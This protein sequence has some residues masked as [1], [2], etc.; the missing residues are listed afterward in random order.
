MGV[1]AAQTAPRGWNDLVGSD[2]ETTFFHRT[3]WAELLIEAGLGAAGLYLYVVEGGELSVGIPS[4]VVRRGPFRVVASMPFGT[5]GGLVLRDGRESAAAASVVDAYAALAGRPGVA[6]AHIMDE[7]GRLPEPPPGF[8]RHTEQAHRIAL[9]G[10]YDEVW[11]GFRPSAR[12]KVRKAEKAGVSVRRAASERDFL[13]YHDMLLECSERWGETCAFGRGFFVSLSRLDRDV[14]QMWLAEQDGEVIGGDLN[15][16]LHGRVMNWGNV[17]RSSA[18]ALAP[19]NLLHAHAMRAGAASGCTVY[20]LGS[21]A[22]IEGVDA[23][24][25]AFGTTVVPIERL[26]HT[27]PWYRAAARLRGHGGRS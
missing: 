21:S 15:F 25:S 4:V 2:P 20:D 19:N 16:V 18:R 22:G 14:V 3:E 9:D 13:E 6:A 27:K 1:E 26:S 12:N 11:S 5:Y 10:G 8:E 7:S 17:S 24:K 23:F